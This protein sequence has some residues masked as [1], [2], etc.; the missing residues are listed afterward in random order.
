MYITW[1]SV[2]REAISLSSHIL[3][4]GI[5]HCLSS[6]L[7]R[8]VETSFV[9]QIDD[10]V[11]C[12]SVVFVAWWHSF[13]FVNMRCNKLLILRGIVSQNVSSS[14]YL[15]LFGHKHQTCLGLVRSISND[16]NRVL[17]LSPASVKLDVE[18]PWNRMVIIELIVSSVSHLV[19][20]AKVSH[21]PRFIL[22]PV[23]HEANLF[24]P[25]VC[26]SLDHA[27]P[28][29]ISGC[30][31]SRMS[32]LILQYS[33]EVRHI[34]TVL[35]LMLCC[36]PQNDPLALDSPGPSWCTVCHYGSRFASDTL[37]ALVWSISLVLTNR[38]SSALRFLPTIVAI[39][40]CLWR[41]WVPFSIKLAHS[42]SV[43][44]VNNVFKLVMIPLFEKSRGTCSR[45]LGCYP[46]QK[47]VARFG[48]IRFSN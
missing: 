13:T 37:S 36:F 21:W 18:I 8:R 26:N 45:S 20:A 48:R 33:F 39:G 17:S 14:H 1:V 46:L 41:L 7:G 15:K 24:L 3:K 6:C 27:N 43:I 38:D 2:R 19:W 29:V 28:H 4:V 31:L 40:S 22:S 34:L 23:S 47:P 30:R 42:V 44:K 35:V 32:L 9:G 10:W 5:F 12:I 11:D 16:L 25:K